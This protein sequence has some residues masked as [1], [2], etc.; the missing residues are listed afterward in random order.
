[1]I[2]TP[3]ANGKEH[4]T[5]FTKPEVVNFILDSVNMFSGKH[6]GMK[7]ILDPAVGEGAFIMPIIKKLL[8]NFKGDKEK[9]KFCLQNISAYEIDTDKY[10]VLLAKL[11]VLFNDYKLY[12][13]ERYVNLFNEDYLLANTNLFDIIIG[14][15]PYIRYDRIPKDKIVCYRQLFSCFKYRCDIYISFFEKGLES[16][17]KN[18][19]LSFICPDRWLNNQYGKPLRLAIKDNFSYKGIVKLKNFNPFNEDVNAY[20]AIVTIQNARNKNTHF[21]MADSIQSLNLTGIKKSARNIIA[22]NNAGEIVLSDMNKDLLTIE[23]QNFKIGIGV[24]SGADDVFLVKK[25]EAIIE[26]ELL[27][28]I[29]TRKD[30]NGNDIDWKHTYIINP[31]DTKTGKLV[32][33]SLYPN[34]TKYLDENRKRLFNRYIAKKVPDNWYRTIDKIDISLINRPKLL[35]PDISTKNVIYFDGGYYYPHHNFYYIIGKNINDL[36]L[37]KA[38]LSAKFVIDQIA[39]KCTLM[40]GGALRRQAQTLRK[41]KIPNIQSIPNEMKRK[42]IDASRNNDTGFLDSLIG[43][44]M[45][46]NSRGCL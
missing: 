4:G 31:F 27:V 1:M 14:N 25:E 9:I 40:N 44:L 28:P 17:N 43:S 41:I 13:Y 30:V 19:I 21:Y 39:E 20:P 16:L 12:G 15:P 11:A 6:F 26:D 33:L 38:L 45:S 10:K 36:V 37:L 7:K 34:L 46:A 8:E 32:D 18:G 42:I 23:E 29:I 35:I 24:A 5:V 22:I 3:R 2:Y